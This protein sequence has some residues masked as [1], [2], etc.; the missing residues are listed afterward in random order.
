MPSHEV[1]CAVLS[2][3]ISKHAW[4]TPRSVEEVVRK[5]AI[6]PANADAGDVRD[7]IDELRK[8]AP[9]VVDYDHGGVGLDNSE[10]GPLA[11]YLYYRCDWSPEVIRTRL[12]H[13]RGWEQHDW[14]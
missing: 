4:G 2:F 3:L 11:D 13:Y 1:Y 12:K 5:T 7:A 9:Y 8:V 6:D 10:F 14:A